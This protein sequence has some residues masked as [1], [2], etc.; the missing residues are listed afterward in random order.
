MKLTAQITF[1]E[2]PLASELAHITRRFFGRRARLEFDREKAKPVSNT[3][4]LVNVRIR[5][6]SQSI[7]LALTGLGL[8][9]ETDDDP[10]PYTIDQFDKLVVLICRRLK[11]IGEKT[12]EGV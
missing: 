4:Y 5:A 9:V 6:T 12:K 1:Y 3:S 8:H 2:K 11:G 7:V 10:K